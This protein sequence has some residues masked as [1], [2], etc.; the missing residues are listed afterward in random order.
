MFHYIQT[1]TRTTPASCV[2]QGLCQ[3][4]TSG[5]ASKATSP[6]LWVV[7]GDQLSWICLIDH[8]VNKHSYGKWT[9]YR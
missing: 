9:I 4:T 6:K 8:L 7:G 1:W 3:F 5:A 2:G